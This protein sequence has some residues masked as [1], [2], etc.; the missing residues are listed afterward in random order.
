MIVLITAA[1]SAIGIAL[2]L[3]W[4]LI[5]RFEQTTDD[6][7]VHG[8]MVVVSPQIPG[9]ITA[10]TVNETEV[11]EEGHILITL[12]RIDRKIAF[13]R[14][15]NTLADTVRTIAGLY[16]T[17]GVL[18]GFLEQRKV[19]FTLA[20]QDYKHR[21]GV[22]KEGGVSLEEY[23]HA[24]AAFIGA[25]AALLSTKHELRKALAQTENTSFETHPQIERAK[26][27]VRQTFVDLQRCV[28]RSPA[29]GMV[30][31][32]KAQVGESVDPETP[33]MTIVPL[34]QIWINANFKESKLGQMRIGQPAT[35]TSTIYGSD[36]VYHGEIEGISA[37]TG[38]VL[39]VL[40]PQNATGNWIKIVQRLPVRIK[41]EPSEI[42]RYPLR[43]GLSTTV[44]IDIRNTSGKK[45]PAPAPPGAL[46]TTSV[47]K[48]Q[49]KGVEGIIEGIIKKNSTFSFSVG[50]DGSND[51]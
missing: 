43:L 35:I 26:D 7:Y 25:F 2:F 36:V 20:A 45:I 15:K 6:A 33:L 22:I 11:V 1:L 4:L 39:S 17:V 41:L 28:V 3:L 23:E 13:D 37:G 50:E 31:M 38:S 21:K 14:A 24:E 30:V 42:A 29:R 40:P 8:N 18:K 48:N 47:F 10:V 16:E 49:E 19:E 27:D 51:K 9:N 44:K 34:D 5:W 32:K 12:D 46:Y